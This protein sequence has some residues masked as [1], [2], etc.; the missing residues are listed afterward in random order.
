MVDD[1]VFVVVAGYKSRVP[2]KRAAEALYDAGFSKA[3]ASLSEG[4]NVIGWHASREPEELIKVR[5][6]A[7]ASGLE[8]KHWWPAVYKE[9]PYA[10][11]YRA[12]E[13]LDLVT[14]AKGL[15]WLVAYPMK[16]SP[17]WYLLPFEER[18]SIMAEHIRIARE[19]VGNAN[20]KSYTTYAFGIADYEFLV[21]YEVSDLAGWVE[22]V[23]RLRAAQ[24]RKWV[25]LEEP[26]LVGNLVG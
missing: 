25:V 19:A 10:R 9:S 5:E 13:V 11:G 3:Y 16:K 6:E 12:G 4:V 7:L 20:I 24:A 17:E 8:E 22:V 1:K 23:E 18:R 26:V 14:R 15:P 2:A 21:I